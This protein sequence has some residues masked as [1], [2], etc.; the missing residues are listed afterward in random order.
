MTLHLQGAEFDRTSL[1]SC[2]FYLQLMNKNLLHHQQ[3]PESSDYLVLSKAHQLKDQMTISVSRWDNTA[4]CFQWTQDLSATQLRDFQFFSLGHQLV[5]R[6]SGLVPVVPMGRVAKF[7]ASAYLK[8]FE[9]L[10]STF[11]GRVVE[12]VIFSSS[13]A[14][15][16][17]GPSPTLSDSVYVVTSDAVMRFRSR[18]EDQFDRVV[19]PVDWKDRVWRILYRGQYERS[20]FSENGNAMFL[21]TRNGEVL[22]TYLIDLTEGFIVFEKVQSADG[23]QEFRHVARRIS[24]FR[25]VLEQKWMMKNSSEQVHLVPQKAPAQTFK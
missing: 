9:F 6:A 20:A 7:E 2:Q 4:K 21:Q 17:T 15:A 16:P 23:K 25:P 11:D 8:D 14:L 22:R 5:V 18:I 24:E 13:F 19:R 10:M 1:S 12:G 3:I